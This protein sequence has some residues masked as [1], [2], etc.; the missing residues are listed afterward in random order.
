MLDA[1]I[2]HIIWEEKYVNIFPVM[3]K[4]IGTAISFTIMIE[5]IHP[6]ELITRLSS[7]SNSMIVVE[8][9]YLEFEE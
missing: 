3:F 2:G 4:W 9:E 1:Y 5:P 8:L 6:A 7:K